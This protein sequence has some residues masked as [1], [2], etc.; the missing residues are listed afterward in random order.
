MVAGDPARLRET[1]SQFCRHNRFIS[2]CPICAKG[3]V[4]DPGRPAERRPSPRTTSTTARRSTGPVAARPARGPY[5]SAGPYGGRELR[6]EKVPGGL[7]LASWLGGQIERRAPVL[8]LADLPGLIAVAVEKD[9]FGSADAAK[10]D[11]IVGSSN[12]AEP[13]SFGRSPGRAGELKDELRV[14]PLAD[15][16]LRI[17]RWVLRP[18][19]GWELQEAPVMLPP[20]RFAQAIADAAARG[21]LAAK[22]PTA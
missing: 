20:A 12:G 1:L 22:Q 4:L 11:G 9:L 6:L 21:V 2:E 15:G 5:A 3:T 8:A 19:R 14:E 10:L 17:A 13:G 18:N 7:R 16:E